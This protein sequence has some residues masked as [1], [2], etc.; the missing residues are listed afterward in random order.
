MR[1]VFV[2]PVC[3]ARNVRHDDHGI[4]PYDSYSGQ[5][6]PGATQLTCSESASMNPDL[7]TQSVLRMTGMEECKSVVAEE[8][9]LSTFGADF[10]VV[11]EIGLLASPSRLDSLTT[12]P[13]TGPPL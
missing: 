12:G 13:M 6:L 10:I 8:F 3:V 7:R 11:L 9:C 2:G 5:T 4:E 1:H